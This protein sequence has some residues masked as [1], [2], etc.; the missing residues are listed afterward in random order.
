MPVY[1]KLQKSK[2][3]TGLL[4]CTFIYLFNKIKQ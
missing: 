1:L 3:F 4:V 2:A